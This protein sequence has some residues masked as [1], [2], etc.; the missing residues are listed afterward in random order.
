[1]IP[2]G[3]R[4]L[5][6]TRSRDVSDDLDGALTAIVKS[7]PRR[8]PLLEVEPRCGLREAARPLSPIIAPVHKALTLRHGIAL[9]KSCL[10]LKADH[11]A[12]FTGRRWWA[13]AALR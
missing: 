5:D 4:E 6:E 2:P 9:A 1:M 11:A 10:T 7:K 3:V 13:S 8:S 12:N